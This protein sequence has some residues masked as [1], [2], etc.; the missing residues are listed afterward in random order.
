MDAKKRACKKCGGVGWH[1]EIDWNSC[2]QDNEAV[3]CDCPAGDA[4]R[5]KHKREAERA[6]KKENR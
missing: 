6:R 4:R 2:R 3:Y 5:E 1:Y